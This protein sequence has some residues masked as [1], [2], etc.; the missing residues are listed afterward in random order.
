MY[1][2]Q[3]VSVK[4]VRRGWTRRGTLRN[5][6]HYPQKIV[7]TNI[8]QEF[9][10]SNI[11]IAADSIISR[12]LFVIKQLWTRKTQHEYW[13]VLTL[14]KY[15]LN[16]WYWYEFFSVTVTNWQD[17]L[18]RRRISWSSDLCKHSAIV[19]EW[20]FFSLINSLWQNT[21]WACGGLT[22]QTA[23]EFIVGLPASHS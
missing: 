6:N 11:L 4:N 19:R 15:A 3:R 7:H 1:I 12:W 17:Q 22:S 14:S 9:T 5:C 21:N 8:I 2:R 18:D 16:V 10:F 20:R 13:S 23:A